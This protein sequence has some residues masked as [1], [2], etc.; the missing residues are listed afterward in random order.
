MRPKPLRIDEVIPELRRRADAVER[1]TL[2]IALDGRSGTGKSTLA[3]QIA[4]AFPAVIVQSDDFFIGGT[5]AEWAARPVSERVEAIDWR[6]LRTEALEPLLAGKA[7]TWHP[8]DFAT[9]ARIGPNTTTVAPKP[10]IVLDGNF[11]NRPELRDIID[12]S[13]LL[14]LHDETRRKRL[15]DREGVRFMEEWHAVWDDVE[16]YY[17]E[18]ISPPSVYD[19]LAAH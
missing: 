4:A 7:A 16:G 3:Q 15:V 12:I 13:I 18:Q 8:F 5:E 19:Y 11:S 6:R 10:V 14:D 2:L 17:Y 9:R 1:R